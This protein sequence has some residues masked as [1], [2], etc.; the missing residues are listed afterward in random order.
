MINTRLLG[1]RRTPLERMSRQR[2]D[3][4]WLQAQMK[5]PGTRFMVLADLSPV[6]R[7][8]EARSKAALAWFSFADIAKFRL[9]VSEA[10]Y[11]G[12][13]E[14]GE[15]I[16][17]ICVPEHMTRLAPGGH[18]KLRPIVDLRSLAR[19]GVM[20]VDDMMLAGEARSLWSWHL[21]A[22]HCGHCGGTTRVKD[23][24]WKR[25]CWACG[26]EWFPRTDPVVIMLIT[27]GEGEEAQCLL[28]TPLAPAND[29][30]KAETAKYYKNMYSALAGFVEHGETIEDAV[31]REVMEEAGIEVG[32]V[33]YVAS[34]PWPFPHSLMI[35]CIGKALSSDLTI[36]REEIE[37][38]R[39]FSRKEAAAMLKGNHEEG[40]IAPGR[41][42]IA[43]W[44]LQD[45][46]DGNIL[47]K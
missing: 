38:A 23:G 37:S 4:A 40:L 9:P 16:F 41:Y 6:I 46:V 39:W 15:N 10:L 27:R 12:R 28:A 5:A 44:L 36:D 19:Q 13:N 14:Q 21:N 22:R 2:G 3:G 35:G 7:S 24:G 25:K 33:S 31:R 29:P 45:F 1:D 47:P 17:A 18:E 30:I 26:H 8:N 34:Q 11:L 32:E 42:A 43:N 20:A